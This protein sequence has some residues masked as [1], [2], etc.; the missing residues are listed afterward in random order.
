M[1]KARSQASR[2]RREELERQRQAQAAKD[3]K[4]RLGLFATGLVI[5]VVVVVVCVISLTG[6]KTGGDVTPPHGDASTGITPYPDVADGAPTLEIF[7]DFQCPNCKSLE[8]SLADT[9]QQVMESGSAKVV[10]RTMTF[11]DSLN[12][13]S[14]E[15]SSTRAAT[16]AACADTLNNNYYFDFARQIYENQPTTEGDG[17]SDTLLRETIPAAVGI[18]GDQ[19]T[20]FQQCY[21]QKETGKFVQSVDDAATAD[22]ITGTPV[23][24]LNGTNITADLQGSDDPATTLTDDIAAVS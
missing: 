5:V 14:N 7:Q 17:Y 18:T 13:S 21:D 11:L 16:A 8:T 19:L 24:L 12:S 15:D 3:R 23:Y 2:S 6:A 4:I 10:F 22:G 9:L 20:Q 1:A